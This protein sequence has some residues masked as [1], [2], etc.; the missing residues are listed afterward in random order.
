MLSDTLFR[1]PRAPGLRVLQG[2][3]NERQLALHEDPAHRW[4]HDQ[5]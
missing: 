4:I 5:P 3:G 1:V 2:R